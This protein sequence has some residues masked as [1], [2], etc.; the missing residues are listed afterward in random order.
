MTCWPAWPARFAVYKLAVRQARIRLDDQPVGR[1]IQITDLSL[2]LPFLSNLPAHLAVRTEPRLAFTLQ[3]TRFDTGANAP[4]CA[5]QRSGELRLA[6]QQLDLAPWLAYLPGGLPLQVQAARVS[7]DLRLRF[8]LPAQGPPQLSLLGQWHLSQV[9]LALAPRPGADA[10]HPAAPL[11]HWQSLSAA[12]DDV[13]PLAQQVTLGVVTLQGAELML[14]RDARGRLPWPLAG[15]AS[16]DA[17]VAVPTAVPTAAPA[18][19]SAQPPATS[20]PPAPA[21]Q[22]SLARLA[23]T[24][25]VLHWADAGTQPAAALHLDGLSLQGEDLHWPAVRPMPLKAEARLRPAGPAPAAAPRG[26]LRIDGRVQ[27]GQAGLNLSVDALPLG[28]LQPCLAALLRPALT[29]SLTLNGRLD[30]SDGSAAPAWQALVLSQARVDLPVHRI[31][32]GRLQLQ[33]PRLAVARDSQGRLDAETWLVA[34]PAAPARPAA[35]ASTAP[36][37]Q[38]Q[39]RELRWQDGHLTLRRLPLHLLMPYADAAL[40]VLLQSADLGYQGQLQARQTPTCGPGCWRRPR[41]ATTPPVTWRCVAAWP[42]ATPSPRAAC[43]PTACSW[44]G[45]SCAHPTAPM[46]PGRRG[47]T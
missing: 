45:P 32:L 26:G 8:A 1:V 12:L 47:W 6:V 11:L 24:D 17:A 3:G 38:L 43:P 4:P 36:P 23:L 21:W 25:A 20:T 18:A 33:G 13:Q 34:A 22:L 31:S 40:P 42:C 30:W 28:L 46:Q 29:G 39:L 27:P 15:D 16:T 44:P 2:G 9:A 41:P 19:S 7:T 14:T 35:P 10:T 5:Q 37:W